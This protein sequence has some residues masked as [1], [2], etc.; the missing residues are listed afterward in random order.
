[1]EEEYIRIVNVW[2]KVCMGQRNRGSI[3][4]KYRRSSLWL[5]DKQRF[6]KYDTKNLTYKSKWLIHR[7]S[8]NES[9]LLFVVVE[10]LSLI[11]LFTTLWPAAGQASLSSTISQSLPKFMCTTSMMPF[12]HLTLCYPLIL[13]LR[14]FPASGSFSVSQLFVLGGQSIT[15]KVFCSLRDTIKE[16]RS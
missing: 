11:W 1:M 15:L 16:K 4:E 13:C 2:E 5:W 3:S 6:L 10:S 8:S 7:I 14:S 9:I 12:N